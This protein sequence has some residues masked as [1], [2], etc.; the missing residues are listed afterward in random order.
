MT[1]ECA[2][3]SEVN[4]I[5]FAID[6]DMIPSVSA[7]RITAAHIHTSDAN[8][9]TQIEKSARKAFA[10]S[11]F[12]YQST[13]YVAGIGTARIA[14]THFGNKTIVQHFHLMI[15]THI[16]RNRCRYFTKNRINRQ[17]IVQKTFWCI[18]RRD[19]RL[20]RVSV[21]VVARNIIEQHPQLRHIGLHTPQHGR[22]CIHIA[23]PRNVHA[24]VDTAGFVGIEL[25]NGR[26]NGFVLGLVGRRQ[27]VVAIPKYLVAARH[28]CQY[29]I[30]H[31]RSRQCQMQTQQ[32]KQ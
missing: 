1:G 15:S 7:I 22:Q 27:L 16:G 24:V 6:F 12:F 3:G 29:A 17:Q 21:I 4:H 8:S 2:I 30:F 31:S 23:T 14:I 32:A 5:P 20:I 19:A 25:Q 11:T 9:L 26:Q 13:F 28:K 10:N 18:D